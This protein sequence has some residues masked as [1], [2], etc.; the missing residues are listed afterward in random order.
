MYVRLV[1]LYAGPFDKLMASR[2]KVVLFPYYIRPSTSLRFAQGTSSRFENPSVYTERALASRS[3][4]RA[5]FE[6]A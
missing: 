6:P 1:T 2:I 5:G 3:V 4:R